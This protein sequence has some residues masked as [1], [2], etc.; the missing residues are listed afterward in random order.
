[1]NCIIFKLLGIIWYCIAIKII[2]D[3]LYQ[4]L[5]CSYKGIHFTI[6]NHIYIY[7]HENQE[8]SITNQ[9]KG[10]DHQTILFSKLYY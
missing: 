7:M 1:M 2:N 9:N 8:K 5:W 6:I 10:Q 3:H 4:G